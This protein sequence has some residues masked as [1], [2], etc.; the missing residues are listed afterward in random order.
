MRNHKLTMSEI[1]NKECI[2]DQDYVEVFDQLNNAAIT[3]VR[4]AFSDLFERK[5]GKRCDD[6]ID[7]IAFKFSKKTLEA[8]NKIKSINPHFGWAHF[9][10]LEICGSGKGE[11]ENVKIPN[12]NCTEKFIYTLVYP[13]LKEY[14]TFDDDKNSAGCFYW[15]VSAR[16]I[17]LEYDG[18]G[19]FR[20]SDSDQFVW[21]S[22]QKHKKDLERYRIWI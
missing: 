13:A 9:D 8:I 5:N 16:T 7:F 1:K 15:D 20:D 12:L 21:W 6:S 2:T 17:T 18:V 19:K 14:E 11:S 3:E 4:I 22:E 10:E